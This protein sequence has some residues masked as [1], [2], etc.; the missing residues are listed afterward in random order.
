M[1]GLAIEWCNGEIP[2]MTIF[3][4]SYLLSPEMGKRKQ[5]TCEENEIVGCIMHVLWSNCWL[6]CRDSSLFRWDAVV[7]G[8]I[9]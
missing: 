5:A 7:L 1:R 6:V 4:N 8:L 9:S 2:R 3:F